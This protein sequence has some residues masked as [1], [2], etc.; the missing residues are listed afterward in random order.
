MEISCTVRFLLYL[1][2]IKKLCFPKYSYNIKISI[3]S[4]RLLLIVIRQLI[5]FYEDSRR[6]ICHTIIDIDQL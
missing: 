4:I 3:E 5:T 1:V 6:S 2:S